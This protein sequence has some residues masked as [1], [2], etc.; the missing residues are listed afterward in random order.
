MDSHYRSPPSSSSAHRPSISAGAFNIPTHDIAPPPTGVAP[1]ASLPPTPPPAMPYPANSSYISPP[2]SAPL[3][4]T[5]PFGFDT[6]TQST[7]YMPMPPQPVRRQS[8]PVAFTQQGSGNEYAGGFYAPAISSSHDRPHP[9]S[10][11]PP[12]M[13]AESTVSPATLVSPATSGVPSPLSSGHPIVETWTSPLHDKSIYQGG[14]VIPPLFVP[15]L[16]PC[17]ESA[18]SD[19]LPDLLRQ[20]PRADDTPRRPMNA[21]FVFMK[22]RRAQFANANPSMS[23][24]DLSK[25]LGLEWKSLSDIQ[26][27]PWKIL[28]ERLIRAFKRRN[29]D[30]QY[31]RGGSRR[32]KSTQNS[33]DFVPPPPPA[34]YSQGP[35]PHYAPPLQTPRYAP[36]TRPKPPH[37]TP[38]TPPFH[39]GWSTSFA[40][41][42]HPPD[43]RRG[44][45]MYPPDVSS[46]FVGNQMYP[47]PVP[48]QDQPGTQYAVWPQALAQQPQEP[49]PPA[50]AVY[51]PEEWNQYLHTHQ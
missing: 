4:A 5:N 23:T 15:S 36:Y 18:D 10:S 42:I 6:L 2:S 37:Q 3:H 48:P 11:P 17:G 24:G 43:D 38:Y 50:P 39:T 27:R 22:M 8:H 49:L 7:S 29:P 25:L 9:P 33:P 40:P 46:A 41:P 34:L 1:T 19:D 14:A 31:E 21:F 20:D 30:Y 32:K 44:Y 16:G 47:P 35:G 13:T 45:P 28:H 26:Q 12:A 51:H